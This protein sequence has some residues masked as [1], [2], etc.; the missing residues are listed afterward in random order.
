MKKLQREDLL[1]L[2]HYA[3]ARPKFRAQVMAHKKLRTL[4]IGPDASLYF[5]DRLSMQYQV[6]EMLRI[7][8]LFERAAIQEELDTYNALIPDGSNWKATFMIE[9]PDVAERQQRLQEL[10]GIEQG[11]WIQVAD[12]ARVSP[13]ANEDIER[14]ERGKTS[15]VHFLRF[16]LGPEMVRSVKSGAPVSAGIDHPRYRHSVAPLGA[17][18]RD[19]LAAD[20]D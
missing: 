10:V 16:E 4:P 14:T 2:E 3:E 9:Y 15:S 6:Q 19:S 1:S 8:R 7:E 5:E 17:E 18:L 20:L 12:C 13:I 11:I